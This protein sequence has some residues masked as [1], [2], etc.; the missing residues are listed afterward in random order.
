MTRYITGCSIGSII[1][2]G[3]N[4][5]PSDNTLLAPDNHNK[6]AQRQVFLTILNEKDRIYSKQFEHSQTRLNV[7]GANSGAWIF[8]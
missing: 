8:I 7:K 5:E 6:P 1:N 4:P 3:A 2:N